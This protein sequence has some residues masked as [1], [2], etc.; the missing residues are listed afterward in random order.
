VGE[1]LY[2]VCGGL[3][4]TPCNKGGV[5]CVWGG[6]G[7]QP[8]LVVSKISHCSR[9]ARV[10]WDGVTPSARVCVLC[11]RSAEG[12]VIHE[13]TLKRGSAVVQRQGSGVTLTGNCNIRFSHAC[14]CVNM[15]VCCSSV[16]EFITP[17]AAATACSVQCHCVFLVK[18][19][20]WCSGRW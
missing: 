10:T 20:L 19:E 3:V 13:E 17:A 2:S 12:I 1:W 16:V 14:V 11:P 8:G 6:G 4:C 18:M 9:A 15:A 5:V 7:T